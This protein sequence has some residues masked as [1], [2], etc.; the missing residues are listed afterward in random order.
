M[1]HFRYRLDSYLFRKHRDRDL[2]TESFPILTRSLQ[3]HFVFSRSSSL[4]VNYLPFYGGAKGQYLEVKE[5]PTGAIVSEKIVS[6]ENI[7]SENIVKNNGENLLAR[8]LAAN[9]QSLKTLSSS[10]L[11]LHTLGRK[12]GGL[13]TSDK[14]RFQSEL[15]SL[16]E[17]ASNTVKLIEEL[18]D[19]VDLLFTSNH[20]KRQYENDEDDVGEEGVSIDNPS[21]QP[22]IPPLEALEGT[23]IAQAAP[24]GLAVVGENGLASSRP[25][26]TAVAAS[27][28]AIARP[29]GTAIAGLDPA[30]LGINFQVN[31]S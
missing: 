6:E 26:G 17:T 1:N 3:H 16:G 29:V 22:G 12:T 8:V 11:R 14:A 19:N 18:G 30:L 2:I 10:V 27:G 4:R 15:G 24:I 31:K 7:S 23:I 21:G 13:N 20:T 25:V 9:L 5:D 28:I